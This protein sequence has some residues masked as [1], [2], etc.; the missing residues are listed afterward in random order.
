MI[1]S[2]KKSSVFLDGDL[3]HAEARRGRERRE[4]GS[5][6]PAAAIDR[7]TW[8]RVRLGE[9][10]SQL[11]VSMGRGNVIS[12]ET[13]ESHPGNYPVFSSSA[14]GDGIIGYYADYMF[15][16]ERISWSID[17]GGRFF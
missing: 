11:I 8:K 3:S 2:D 1:S 10:A 15:D 6:F 7:S 9:L 14:T 17:G 16:D 13:I 4:G 12:R 5:P